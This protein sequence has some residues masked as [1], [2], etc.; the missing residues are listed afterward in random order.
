MNKAKCPQLSAS[1]RRLL[2]KN[3]CRETRSD[4][5]SNEMS[6][7][8]EEPALA[9]SISTA[10]VSMLKRPNMWRLTLQMYRF[11]LGLSSYLFWCVLKKKVYKSLYIPVCLY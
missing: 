3:M 4:S 7:Y 6:F 11:K 8:L 10:V 1:P 2:H 5:L 9:V